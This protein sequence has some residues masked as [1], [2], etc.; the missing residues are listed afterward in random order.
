MFTSYFSLI[1]FILQ[2]RVPMTRGMSSEQRWQ[3]IANILSIS[4]PTDGNSIHHPFSHHHPL[5]NYTHPHA[6]GMTYGPDTTR[7][8]LLHNATLT[9]PM[10]ELNGTVPYSNLGMFICNNNNIKVSFGVYAIMEITWIHKE[11]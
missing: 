5:H 8:V 7:G 10:G 4:T 9:P 11:T 1:I 6:H 3:D 2:G